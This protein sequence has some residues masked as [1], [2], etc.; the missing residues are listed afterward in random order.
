MKKFLVLA[1]IVGLVLSS[2]ATF[3]VKD[4]QVLNL[5]F[6]PKSQIKEAGQEEIAGYWQLGPLFG[7]A[8]IINIGFADF[9]E[10]TAGQNYDV[11]LRWY[12]VLTKVSAYSR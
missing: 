5:G 2:C 8:G 12:V 6:I 10:A 9:E 4:G 11:Q 3:E 1:V 7:G